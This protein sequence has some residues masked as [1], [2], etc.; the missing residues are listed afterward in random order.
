MIR[1]D[2]ES[3]LGDSG[4]IGL[5]KREEIVNDPHL[6][7]VDYRLI[8]R[9]SSWSKL[10]TLVKELDMLAIAGRSLCFTN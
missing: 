10:G 6:S 2:D 5:D 9:S 1:I 8:K 3:V 7:K 4:Y